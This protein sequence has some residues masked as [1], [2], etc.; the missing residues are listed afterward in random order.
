MVHFFRWCFVFCFFAVSLTSHAAVPLQDLYC[1]DGQQ[2]NMCGSRESR[3]AA[4]QAWLES[5]GVRGVCGNGSSPAIN[6]VFVIAESPTSIT[7]NFDERGCDGSGP[8]GNS[9]EGLRGSFSRVQSS[10]P[11]NSTQSGSSCICNSGF[12][13]SGDQCLPPNKDDKCAGDFNLSGFALGSGKLLD[14]QILNGEVPSGDMCWPYDSPSSGCT[15]RFVQDK[16]VTMPGG[17][18]QT[19]GRIGMYQGAPGATQGKACDVP[20]A[21]PGDGTTVEEKCSKAGYASSESTPGGRVCL[22]PPKCPGGFGGEV[23]FQGV[24]QEVCVKDQGTNVVKSEKNTET[25]NKDGSTD[26]VNEKTTCQGK[27]CTTEKTTT[28]TPSGGGS[29]TVINSS[30]V[31]QSKEDYCKSNANSAQCNSSANGEKDGKGGSFG[32][33]CDGGF[34]CEGDALQCAQVREQYKRNC[35]M[36]DK[37]KD[38]GSLTNKALNGTD[39]KSADAL[40]ASA[41]QVNVASSF[42]QSGYGWSRSCPSDTRIPLNFGGVSSEF[43]IPYSVT[44]CGPLGI[45]SWAGVGITL[46]GCLVWVVGAKKGG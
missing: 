31:V 19:Y 41:G 21:T 34:T 16:V 7:F 14:S 37:D 33:S 38:A 27:T 29:S 9:G 8:Y 13:Q 44:I 15:V 23:T 30:T 5:P 4:Y 32:G 25:K 1:R 46:L 10:C 20:A 39:D 11:A 42:D 3:K 18:K 36:M 40:K 45:L 43:N 12:T 2:G 22:D 28:N 26:K 6:S 35:E 17:T 24:T